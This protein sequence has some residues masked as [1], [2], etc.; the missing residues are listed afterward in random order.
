MAASITVQDNDNK[1]NIQIVSFSPPDGVTPDHTDLIMS[2]YVDKDSYENNIPTY[3]K[4]F[5]DISTPLDIVP[6]DLG[7]DD[8]TFPDGVYRFTLIFKDASDDQIGDSYSITGLIIYT[9]SI[10]LT[11]DIIEIA[12][13]RIDDKGDYL[14]KGLQTIWRYT[15]ELGSGFSN[16]IGLVNNSLEMLDKLE[17]LQKND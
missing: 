16:A 1:T 5:S 8:D 7:V 12:K 2:I 10:T 6:S 15:L 11:K 9:A 3:S 14:E 17:Y 13:E 4:E